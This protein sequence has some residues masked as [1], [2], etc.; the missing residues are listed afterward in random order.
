MELFKISK[1]K[2]Y[3]DTCRWLLVAY[4]DYFP[5]I[6]SEKPEASNPVTEYLMQKHR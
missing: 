5:T 3:K 4:W 6:L 2:Y 1:Q